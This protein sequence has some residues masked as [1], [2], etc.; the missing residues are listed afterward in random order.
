MN[1]FKVTKNVPSTTNSTKMH[2]SFEHSTFIPITLKGK[3]RNDGGGNINTTKKSKNFDN[4]TISSK[5]GKTIFFGSHSF[6]FSKL[7]NFPFLIILTITIVIKLFFADVAT[8]ATLAI[9]FRKLFPRGNN[10]RVLQRESQSFPNKFTTESSLNELSEAISKD[11]QGLS[12]IVLD[13]SQKVDPGSKRYASEKEKKDWIKMKTPS[14]KIESK[15]SFI[16]QIERAH[17]S[18]QSSVDSQ[19]NVIT[20]SLRNTSLYSTFNNS[21]ISLLNITVLPTLLNIKKDLQKETA[22]HIIAKIFKNMNKT[23]GSS[24]LLFANNNLMS[25]I[26]TASNLKR[27]SSETTKPSKTMKKTDLKRNVG[28]VVFFVFLVIFSVAAPLGNDQLI[29]ILLK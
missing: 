11:F 20:R 1:K 12:K 23:S 21:N 14:T 19:K 24:G 29:Q 17:E 27:F 2:R 7:H 22:P 26:S 8:N 18:R 6:Q 10:S 3:G 25:N 4:D 28:F 9:I 16:K 13:T 5:I 15:V